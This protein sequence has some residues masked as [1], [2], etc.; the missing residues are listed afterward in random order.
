MLYVE[1]L[2][3]SLGRAAEMYALTGIALADSFISAWNVK[4]RVQLVRP[5]TY[6]NA[7]IDPKWKPIINTPPF[8]EYPSGHSVVSGAAAVVL[9]HLFGEVAFS[10]LT[11]LG[12]MLPPRSFDS[13]DQAAEEAALSC[14]WWHS[15]P[16]EH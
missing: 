7:Y 2:K 10:D 5:V 3:L 1:Q 4:Y 6:I 8:P 16:R 9:T 13:F 11:H 14:L 12:R 15:L